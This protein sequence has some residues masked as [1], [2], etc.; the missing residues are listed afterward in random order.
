MNRQTRRAFLGP[1]DIMVTRIVREMHTWRDHWG[2]VG[3]CLQACF[4]LGQERGI[5]PEEILKEIGGEIAKRLIKA[6]S[7]P[8][9]T[10]VDQSLVYFGSSDPT[11]H[12][13][14]VA[15]QRQHPEAM[16]ELQRQHPDIPLLQPGRT[17]H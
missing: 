2:A 15:W 6:L 8:L 3:G 16:L 5:A 9:I 10:E 7:T 13:A 12:N 17:V 4:S 1:V 14:A 11:H